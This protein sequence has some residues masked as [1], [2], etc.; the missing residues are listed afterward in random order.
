MSFI[1]SLPIDQQRLLGTP[2]SQLVGCD[3]AARCTDPGCP[4]NR[5]IPIDDMLLA[6]GD[7]PL[8]ATLGSLRCVACGGLAGRVSLQCHKPGDAVAERLRV[9]PPLHQEPS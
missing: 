2:L 3:V 7:I 9:W 5:P 8:A 6:Y 4:P 1:H